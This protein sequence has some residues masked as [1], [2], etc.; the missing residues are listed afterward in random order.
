MVRLRAAGARKYRGADHREPSGAILVLPTVAAGQQ[1]PVAAWVSAAGWA[2]GLR[3]LLGEVWIVTPDGVVDIDELRRRAR[4]H[5]RARAASAPRLRRRMPV[6]VKTAVK[7]AREWRRARAFRVDPVGPVAR[8]RHRVRLAAPRA[9]PHRRTAPRAPRSACRRSSSCP[10]RSC[11]RPAQWGVRRPGWERW[12]ERAG[13][14][15]AAARGRRRRVRLRDGRR[16]GR[17]AWVSTTR[18]IVITP[19]GSIRLPE[20]VPVADRPDRDATRARASVLD[21]RFVVGWIGSFRRFHTLEQAVDA[22]ARARGRDAAARGRRARACPYRAARARRAQRRA[23]LH[24]HRRARRRFP[25]HLAAMDVGLVLA[26]VERRVPLLAAQAR[27]VPRGRAGRGRASG[28]R[29]SRSSCATASTRCWSLPATSTQ[30]AGALRRLRRRPG[31]RAAHRRRRAGAW[32]PSGGRGT[33]RPRL[34]L[35]GL[36]SRSPGPAGARAQ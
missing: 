4:S 34:V 11:G 18:R 29:R 13:E 20:P 5:R 17:A 7:D 8:P 26:R 12:I 1:G 10:R 21:G 33:A 2:S 14:Q 30:L 6:V 9:V 36:R 19:T 3:R 32:R 31:T 22:V 35:D 25:T 16:A 27:G 15:R 24:R 23:G 28:R